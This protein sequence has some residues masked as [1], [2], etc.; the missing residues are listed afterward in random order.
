[1]SWRAVSAR[2]GVA[3]GAARTASVAAERLG[4]FRAPERRLVANVVDWR[5]LDAAIRASSSTGASSARPRPDPEVLTLRRAQLR[6]HRVGL[7]A[8]QAHASAGHA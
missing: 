1:M 2:I 6:S 5:G 4:D 3:V 7:D 8:A